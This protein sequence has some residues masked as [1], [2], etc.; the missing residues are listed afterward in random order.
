MASLECSPLRPVLPF[1]NRWRSFPEP[2]GPNAIAFGFVG[3]TA[4]T[5]EMHQ[6]EINRG[7]T[8]AS[9]ANRT[10]EE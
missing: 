6:S 5:T 10:R 4:S 9:A 1:R 8:V 7:A 3:A 2:S